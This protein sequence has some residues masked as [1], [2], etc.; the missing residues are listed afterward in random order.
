MHCSMLW[1]KPCL[2][3]SDA[4]KKTMTASLTIF[5]EHGDSCSNLFVHVHAPSDPVLRRTVAHF[6]EARGDLVPH[7][8]SQ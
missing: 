7:V 5:S 1:Q 4:K 8:H 6:G 3:S 2:P